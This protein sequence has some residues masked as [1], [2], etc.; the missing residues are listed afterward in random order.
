LAGSGTSIGLPLTASGSLSVSSKSNLVGYV[1]GST[2]YITPA[3]TSVGTINLSTIAPA[4]ASFN[5]IKFSP[6]GSRIAF[7]QSAGGYYTLFTVLAN[8]TGKVQVGPAD[9]YYAGGS[10]YDG[11]LYWSPDSIHIAFIDDSSGLEAEG[12][13]YIEKADGSGGGSPAGIAQICWYGVSWSPQSDR[14]AYDAL[15]FTLG[16]HRPFAS[17]TVPNAPT[18]LDNPVVAGGDSSHNRFS[19]PTFSPNGLRVVHRSSR[20][21]L[22]HYELFSSAVDGSNSVKLSGPLV[23][24]GNVAY[25]AAR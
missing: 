17:D 20:E 6:D 5:Y 23:T 7:Y 11:P 8:G 16:T 22:S 19:K 12:K 15:D 21:S 1:S 13:L 18:L 24:G 4:A 9:G 25:F 3:T 10:P 2:A 14:V